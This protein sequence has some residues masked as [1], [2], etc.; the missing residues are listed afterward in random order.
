MEPT[1][2][3]A[4]QPAKPAQVEVLPAVKTR[5]IWRSAFWPALGGALIWAAQELLPEILAARR[6]SRD[7][8]QPTVDGDSTRVVRIATRQPRAGRRHRWGRAN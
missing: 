7:G 6:A 8:V 3:T 4:L 5:S 2:E 1:E